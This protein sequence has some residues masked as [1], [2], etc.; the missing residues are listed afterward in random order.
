MEAIVVTF[1]YRLSLLGFFDWDATEVNFGIQDQRV[2][3]KWIRT[4]V[5]LFGG[6]V[7]NIS[8]M[9]QSAGA[10]SAIIQRVH[11]ETAFISSKLILMSPPALPFSTRL[12]LNDIKQDLASRICFGNVSCLSHRTADEL[13]VEFEKMRSDYSNRQLRF[14]PVVDSRDILASPMES[15]TQ[16]SELSD[17]RILLGNVR[18]ETRLFIEKASPLDLSTPVFNILLKAIYP[19]YDSIVKDIYQNGAG[20]SGD[21]RDRLTRITSDSFFFCPFQKAIKSSRNLFAYTFGVPWSGSLVGDYC[22]GQACHSS[23][24][25]YLLKNSSQGNSF[26]FDSR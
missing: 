17:T 15:L 14:L 3:L 23:D 9:G 26:L 20:F 18:N 2:A 25:L 5:S 8:L 11:S 12:H 21:Q 24:L 10:L 4:H 6:D 13:L 16:V 1:N 7:S 22:S 19:G